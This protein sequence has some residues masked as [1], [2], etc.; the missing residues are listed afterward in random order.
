MNKEL[1]IPLIENYLSKICKDRMFEKSP[2]NVRLLSFLVKQAIAG[3][4][5]SEYIIGLELFEERYDP[6]SNDSKV[7][8]Y[9]FNLR[10]K[11]KEYYNNSGKDDTLIFILKKGQYNLEFQQNQ[12]QNDDSKTTHNRY[13]KKLITFLALSI[14]LL[15]LFWGASHLFKENNYCW[16]DFFSSSNNVCIIADQTMI[17]KTINSEKFATMHL[18]INNKSDFI[19]HL[20]KHPDDSIKL[21][22]YSLFSKM[23]PFSVKELTEWFIKNKSDFSLRLESNFEMDEIRNN[24]V[25]YIGQY[26]TMSTSKSI[27]LKDSN[28]FLNEANIYNFTVLKNGIKTVYK[29]A[30]KQGVMSEYAMVSFIELE[31]GKK[32]LFFV[33][34]NDIGVMA[35]VN[36]FMNKN[37]LANF[38]KNLPAN[39]HYFNALFE[40]K[41]ANRTEIDC[42]L[43]EF[44]ILD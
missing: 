21:A 2:R 18:F 29:T 31:K 9:M 20:E 35:T 12:P 19:E 10:K 28:V 44:E 6:E 27:F 7:R 40:V 4:D 32:A 22:D 8:V 26:K 25:L 33:S 41:G 24:N 30:I 1:D 15:G 42:K 13:Y 17:L 37:W 14:I 3:K 23:A 39:K 5:V 34:N 43:V 38:Y 11:I 36:N 16:T